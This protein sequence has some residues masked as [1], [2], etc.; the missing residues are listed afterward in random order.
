M[1]TRDPLHLGVDY[2]KA[3]DEWRRLHKAELH[4]L[5]SSPYIIWVIKL[6]RMR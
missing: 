4:D 5:Y 1:F 6:R 2:D 3:I